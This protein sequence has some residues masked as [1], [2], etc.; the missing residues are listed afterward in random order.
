MLDKLKTL[1]GNLELPA[2]FPEATLGFVREVP[3]KDLEKTKTDGVIANTYH[4]LRLNLV[5]EIK[6][7][8]GFQKFM[9]FEK[10]VISDSGGFQVMSLIRNNGFGKIYD[11]RVVFKL[12]GIET[13]LT[14]EKCIEI[15]IKIGS[16]IVM[17]LD[18]SRCRSSS[19]TRRR[20]G[21]TGGPPA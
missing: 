20:P 2:F 9:D 19:I 16:D 12:N 11:D 1:H 17:C 18:D 15:Q 8:G 13:E 5:E 7:K 10:P 21:A 14:P 6:E 4:L 3:T